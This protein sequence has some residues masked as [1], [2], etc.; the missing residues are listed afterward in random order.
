M[1]LQLTDG[2]SLGFANSKH[3]R[4]APIYEMKHDSSQIRHAYIYFC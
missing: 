4:S 1:L 3:L 2:S